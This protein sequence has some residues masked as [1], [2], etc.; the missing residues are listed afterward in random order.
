[1]NFE[2]RRSFLKQG[3][4]GLALSLLPTLPFAAQAIELNEANLQSGKDA[5]RILAQYA[6]N[7]QY[8][9]IP[10]TSNEKLLDLL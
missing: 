9:D 7:T 10:P 6:L 2:Q 4:T 3:G 1:M 8:E 5:T